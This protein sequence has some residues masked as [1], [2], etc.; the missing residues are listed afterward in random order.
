MGR[1]GYAQSDPGEQGLAEGRTHEKVPNKEQ[2]L[3][4]RF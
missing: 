1:Q 2:V 3:G 4:A